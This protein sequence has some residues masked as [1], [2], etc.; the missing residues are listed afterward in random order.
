METKIQALIIILLGVIGIGALGADFLLAYVGKQAPSNLPYVIATVVGAMG[1]ALAPNAARALT[2]KFTG[3]NPVSV[4][5]EK[6]A[7]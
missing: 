6:P 7:A 2:Q 5:E 1:G 4:T 3:D